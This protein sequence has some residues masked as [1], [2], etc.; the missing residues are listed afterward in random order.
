MA[1]LLLAACGG[2]SNDSN[3]IDASALSL[4]VARQELN[5]PSSTGDTATDGLNWINYRRQQ[6]G[7]QKLTRN[8]TIDIAAQGH[9]NYQNLNNTITHEQ[10]LENPGVTGVT[11]LDRLLSAGYQFGQGSYAYGE[12][13]ASI[14]SADGVRAVEELITAI[15]HRYAI[16]EPMFMEIGVGASTVIGGNTYFTSNFASRG[17]NTGL[18]NGNFVVWPFANQQNVPTV[19]YTDSENPDPEPTR[20]AVGYPISVHADIN[21]TVIINEGAFTIQQRGGL[22]LPVR[23]LTSVTDA[24]YTQASTAAILPLSALAAGTTYDVQFTGTVNG[25]AVQKAWSFK[26]R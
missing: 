22:P 7:E 26:T 21:A 14:D 25:I 15:Y 19:F 1:T 23:L 24:A 2:S 20:N 8:N 17:L 13:I 4:S 12:V 10:T 5:A 9:S 18:G 11:V 6:L 16:F 3:S